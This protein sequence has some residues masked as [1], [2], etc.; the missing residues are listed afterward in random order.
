MR[1]VVVYEFLSL[2]GVAEQPDAFITD[3]DDMMGN[4]LDRVIASQDAVLLGRRI[5]DEPAGF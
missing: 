5:Y 3:F 2:D 1:N 4:N